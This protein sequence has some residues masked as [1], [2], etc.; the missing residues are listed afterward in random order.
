M[1]V[2]WTAEDVCEMKDYQDEVVLD[3]PETDKIENHMLRLRE[4]TGSDMAIHA[5]LVTT[6]VLV[7]SMIGNT[8]VAE[9]LRYR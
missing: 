2:C 8:K 3:E 6:K 5:I 4:E 7:K 1:S 9:Y